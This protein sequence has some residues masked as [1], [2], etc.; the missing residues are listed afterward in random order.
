VRANSPA[1]LSQTDM[2]ALWAN[3]ACPILF[4]NGK[5]SWASNPETDGRMG[6]FKDGRVVEFER[7]GH[8][9]HHDRLDAFLETVRAFL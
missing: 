7:A 5:E 4:V 1:D 2:Q 8:W 9:V 6:W 3:I